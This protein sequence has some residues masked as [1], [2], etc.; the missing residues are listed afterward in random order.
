MDSHSET[1]RRK[2]TAQ[3]K[4]SVVAPVYNEAATIDQFV[5][6]VRSYLESLKASIAYEILLVDDGS[7]DGSSEKLDD[8]VLRYPEELR[9]VHLARNFGHAAAVAAGLD[10]ASGDA[11]V[12]MDS[13]LQD[14]PAVIPKLVEKWR[15]GYR[16]VYVT[17]SSREESFWKRSLFTGFYRLLRMLSDTPFPVDAG[18]FSLMD[19]RVVEILRSLPE[20]NRYLPGLRAWTGFRQT[21]VAVA[22]RPRRDRETRVGFRGLWK[23]SMNAIFSFSY[24]PLFFFRLVGMLAIGLSGLLMCYALYF[25]L[26]STLTVPA[27][28]SEIVAI[29]FFGGINSFGIGILGEYIARIYD[30][31]KGRPAYVVDRCVGV[32]SDG[33][34]SAQPSSAL[35]RMAA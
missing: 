35:R 20:R 21:G 6:E 19:H 13:D 32:E 24:V 16:V 8:L 28:T 29:S 4:L 11:V 26:F 31:L 22:R 17:R 9:V 1:P 12:L 7:T 27:W 15:A 3:P 30:E 14:D 25:K 33:A 23:L 34:N 5:D 18:N 10:H 2:L